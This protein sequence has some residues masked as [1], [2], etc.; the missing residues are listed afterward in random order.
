MDF[1]S[2]HGS[3]PLLFH[4]SFPLLSD[5]FP[6]LGVLRASLGG[7]LSSLV[8]LGSFLVAHWEKSRLGFCRD[9]SMGKLLE[10]LWV[11][12]KGEIQECFGFPIPNY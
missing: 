1:P 7:A 6:V 2:F 11:G 9:N 10:R 8:C 12:A 5:L 4:K 3:F